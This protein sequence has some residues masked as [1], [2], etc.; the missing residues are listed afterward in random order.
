MSA[1]AA[2]LYAR[3][4]FKIFF[5]DPHV[6]NTRYDEPDLEDMES[7]LPVYR[8]DTETKVDTEKKVETEIEVQPVRNPETDPESLEASSSACV[9]VPESQERPKGWVS[10]VFSAVTSV[11]RW[12]K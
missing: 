1:Y 8:E 6:V 9:N 3:R 7:G 12:R 11:F 5:Q 4:H 2:I 10:K